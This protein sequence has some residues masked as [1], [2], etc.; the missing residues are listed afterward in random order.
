MEKLIEKIL[1]T[2]FYDRKETQDDVLSVTELE[3]SIKE[4]VLSRKFKEEIKTDPPNLDANL[5]SLMGSGIHAILE[6]M[7]KDNPDA[8]TEMRLTTEVEGI[9]VSGKFD[10]IDKPI[11]QM[12]DY[13]S[14]Q[15]WT[16]LFD[17]RGEKHI[18][19]LST[20]R[21]LWTIVGNRELSDVGL[22][23][24]FIRDFKLAVKHSGIRKYVKNQGIELPERGIVALPIPL[25]SM[26]KTGEN[27]RMKVEA[28]L[29]GMAMADIQQVT[30][31]D[32]EVWVNKGKW[33][34]CGMYC[35]AARYCDQF[36]KYKDR[37]GK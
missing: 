32:E 10:R 3:K 23:V 14:T 7:D 22:V 17:L 15:M 35:S 8:I 37:G 27:M 36:K 33:D 25:W 31:T 12:Q 24:R 13:K 2:D 18:P 21:Y 1:S 34:K 6:E 19:Q 5:E 28:Y 11:W 26:Q 29:E 30:C 20:Y 4:L 9:T 16:H